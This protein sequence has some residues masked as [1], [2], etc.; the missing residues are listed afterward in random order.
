MVCAELHTVTNGETALNY[1]QHRGEFTDA[2]AAPRPALVLLDVNMPRLD[3]W[4]VLQAIRNDPEL[5]RIPVVMLTTSSREQDIA[6]S[7]DL[8]C[9]S[10][11]TKADDLD[12]FTRMAA[13]LDAYWFELVTLPPY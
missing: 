7:Y 4:Q 12:G 10:F 11:I 2:A 13:G 8:G 5:R 9:N 6:R 1:L 3:G